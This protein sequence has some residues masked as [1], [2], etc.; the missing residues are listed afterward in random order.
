[1]PL[2]FRRPFMSLFLILILYLSFISLGL[3]DSLLG[4][5]WPAMT[6]EFSVPLSYAGGVSMTVAAFTILSSLFSDR[7][8]RRMGTGRVTAFSVLLTALALFGFSVSHSYVLL[9]LW[10]IPYGLGAGGVDAAINNYAAIHLHAKHM[11]WLHCMWGVGAAAGPYIM[12]G[13][14]RMGGTW[15]TG[16]RL[17]A[18]IQILLCVLLFL[19]LPVWK[20]NA[21]FKEGEKETEK[22]RSL[23]LHEVIRLPG[24]LPL[25]VAF[26]SYCAIEQ[27]GILWT[28]SYLSRTYAI[29]PKDAALFGSLFC[30]GMTVGRGLDGFLSIKLSDRWM[31]RKGILSIAVGILIML[32]PVGSLAGKIGLVVIGLGCAPIYP[33]IIHSAPRFFGAENSGAVI[34][35]QMAFAYLGT[36]FMPPTFGLLADGFGILL[37]PWYLLGFLLLLSVLYEYV[38]HCV[39][40]EAENI[41]KD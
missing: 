31:V 5:A 7:V 10:A 23:R 29:T 2:L 30:I 33:A 19:S 34:G 8:T 25:L 26:F 3:P 41:K 38:E 11:N 28:A 1:M 18:L 27:T 16:Y 4:A 37:L 35:V 9:L 32:L 15:N 40:K 36:M 12:G 24:A 22:K 21:I 17:V 39:R 14:M 20:K 13:V 6:E